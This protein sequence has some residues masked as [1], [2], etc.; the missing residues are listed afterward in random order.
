MIKKA[1]YFFIPIVALALA[2]CGAGSGGSPTSETPIAGDALGFATQASFQAGPTIS[3]ILAN[4]AAFF[5]QQVTLQGM[6]TQQ[7]SPGSFLFNDGTGSMPVDFQAPPS[8]F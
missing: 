6:A 2:G 7:L 1:R 8:L 3:T 5:G 4:P